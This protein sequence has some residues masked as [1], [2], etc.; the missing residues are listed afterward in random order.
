MSID[1]ESVNNRS[2]GVRLPLDAPFPMS[3]HKVEFRVKG[4]EHVIA[5]RGQ[6][7]NDF[8]LAGPCVS[9]DFLPELDTQMPTKREVI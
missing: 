1:S 4:Q 9:E 6:S 5:P 3:E 2:Q 7:W 8:F